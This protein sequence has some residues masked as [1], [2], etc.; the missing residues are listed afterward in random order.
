MRRS[1]KAAGRSALA[2]AITFA[3]IGAGKADDV[4]APWA[5]DLLEGLGKPMISTLNL[6]QTG[7]FVLA[8]VGST[9]A[10][11][12]TT[13]KQLNESQMKEGGSVVKEHG[14]AVSFR[15]CENTNV[16]FSGRIGE[17]MISYKA[18]KPDDLA[19][20]LHSI[21][22]FSQKAA[23]GIAPTGFGASEARTDQTYAT[24][25]TPKGLTIKL[26]VNGE[27]HHLIWSAKQE[28]K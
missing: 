13:A 21:V 15:A 3:L 2:A 17:V 20:E 7:V 1:S 27:P 14:F 22:E 23:P 28:C 8:D 10:V 9:F 18:E 4:V 24:W 5:K 12:S 19:R 26:A 6:Y 16:Y 25:A 11:Y